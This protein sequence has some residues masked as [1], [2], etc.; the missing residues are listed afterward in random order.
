MTF[1]FTVF[2]YIYDFSAPVCA[3]LSASSMPQACCY[4]FFCLCRHSK[5]VVRSPTSGFAFCQAHSVHCL[6]VYRL[7]VVATSVAFYCLY[8][9][10]EECP[11]VYRACAVK[12]NHFPVLFCAVSF[13]LAKTICRELLIKVPHYF[14]PRFF[15]NN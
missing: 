3:G 13:V 9:V 4:T 15:G 2:F 10:S 6:V 7:Y 5:T 12:L 1:F 14:I 8:N 11:S